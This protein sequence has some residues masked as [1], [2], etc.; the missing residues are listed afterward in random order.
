MGVHS[1]LADV[2][3]P[4][5]LPCSGTLHKEV[6]YLPLPFRE[7]GFARSFLGSLPDEVFR[8][9]GGDL[10]TEPC[11]P[12]GNHPEGKEEFLGSGFFQYVSCHAAFQGFK[13][14][15]SVKVHGEGRHPDAGQCL[16]KDAG[17]LNAAGFGHGK[18]E[19]DNVGAL[20]ERQRHAFPAASGHAR[21]LEIILPGENVLKSCKKEPVVVDHQDPYLHCAVPPSNASGATMATVD[22]LPFSE[23]TRISPPTE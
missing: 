7:G 9:E 8:H 6:Q 17:C 19:N 22:P 11:F 1:A 18:V 23:K 12:A 10:G 14:H 20:L 5:Y 16:R 4:G 13:N 3:L 2:E 15:L 21:H